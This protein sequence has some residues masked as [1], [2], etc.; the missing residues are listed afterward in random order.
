MR[1]YCSECRWCHG[2]SEKDS[3]CLKAMT[4]NAETDHLEHADSGWLEDAGPED[5]PETFPELYEEAIKAC[6][7]FAIFDH[8]DEW[9]SNDEL[10]VELNNRH[11]HAGEPLTPEIAKWVNN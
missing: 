10:F 9:H 3:E 6:K 7:E 11:G 1:K 5:G 4:F 8:N 2:V